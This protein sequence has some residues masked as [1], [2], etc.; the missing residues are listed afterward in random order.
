MKKTFSTTAIQSLTL[1]LFSALI[2]SSCK[3]QF[4]QPANN[5][6]STEVSAG[7]TP[8]TTSTPANPAIVFASDSAFKYKG[9]T[10]HAPCMFVADADG[11][12]RTMIYNRFFT[13]GNS[14]SIGGIG[15]AKWSGNG[16]QICF[17]GSIFSTSGPNPPYP[18]DTTGSISTLNFT[19][20]NGVPVT[21]NVV[22]ILNGQATGTS[23]SSPAWSPVANEI[24][25]VAQKRFVPT[26]IQIIP[27]TGGIPATIYTCP[28]ATDY[29]VGVPA[30]NADGT[31]IAFPLIYYN[32]YDLTIE[33]WIKIIDR[34]TSAEIQSIQ[35]PNVTSG[36]ATGLEWSKTNNT[37]LAFETGRRIY[38]IDYSTSLTPT[39]VTAVNSR[40]P[41]WSPDDSKIAYTS[42][43]NSCPNMGIS[44]LTLSSNNTIFISKKPDVE[45][46]WKR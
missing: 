1:F 45:A 25:F 43:D 27:S 3:K 12:H 39:Q 26:K 38:T 34:T 33:Q 29:G 18:I 35:I 5:P 23:Y 24:V 7:K 46:N 31:K 22:K 2:I 8:P 4:I 42:C 10:Y 41:T 9:Q 14:V 28:N 40:Y 21:S 20:I 32:P 6:V 17:G 44:V 30:F 13:S 16:Q 19:V 11:S 36:A 15:G 37:K